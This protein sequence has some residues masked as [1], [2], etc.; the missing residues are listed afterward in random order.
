MHTIPT[1]RFINNTLSVR[2]LV[3]LDQSD[4]S[5]WN[6][7]VW[8]MRTATQK[9]PDRQAFTY[10]LGHA[11][12]MHVRC[13]LTGYGSQAAVEMVF[14]WV[15]P[16]LIDDPG[17]PGEVREIMEQVLH[18]PLLTEQGLQEARYLIRARLVRQQEDP[19][20]V[21]LLQALQA[22]GQGTPLAVPISG[23]LDG[24]ET[25]TLADVQRLWRR[26]EQAPKALYAVGCLEPA[27][28][29]FLDTLLQ[30]A[31]QAAPHS[32]LPARKPVTVMCTR[33]ISQTSLVQGYTTGV[34]IDSP[35]SPALLMLSAIL[36]SGQKS[37]LFEEIRE[38]HSWCYSISSS[39]IRFDGL[40]L[41]SA[42]TRSE[43]LEDLQAEIARQIRRLREDDYPQSLFDAALLELADGIMAREDFPASMIE[44]AFQQDL[45]GM[46]RSREEQIARLRAVTRRDVQELACQ[47]ELAVTSIVQE[48][49]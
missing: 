2:A 25:V 33:D 36:G 40:L 26:L 22:A 46:H 28:E 18:H 30:Q 23:T 42:G 27:M 1:S 43:Y 8:M 49:D 17:Y 13:G 6:V 15:R 5:A 11:Y 7:L 32:V 41:V 12:A 38:R 4:I 44:T 35:R 48:E 47:L 39:L 24:L 21:A 14:E 34:S 9:W 20:T 3:P 19:D 10:A 37:L 16:Q 45:L 31:P 29:R